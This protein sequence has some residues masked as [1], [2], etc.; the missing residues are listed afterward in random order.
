MPTLKRLFAFAREHQEQ[1]RITDDE[2]RVEL[3]NF[4]LDKLIERH[5]GVRL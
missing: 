3:L 1:A 5:V 4:I 2:L